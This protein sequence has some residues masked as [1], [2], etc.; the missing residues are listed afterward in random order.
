MNS[1]LNTK[2]GT[3]FG[4]STN[5][6]GMV[7]DSEFVFA[8]IACAITKLG[9]DSH[10]FIVCLDGPNVCKRVLKLVDAR[11]PRIFGQRCCTHAWHLLLGDIVKFE[12]KHVLSRICAC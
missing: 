6:T 9:G 1:V 8:D 11:M 5:A 2:L 7:K 10:V 3:F 12:F 4:Q